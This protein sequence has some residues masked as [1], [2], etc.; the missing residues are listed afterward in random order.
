VTDEAT[1]E[2]DLPY[3]EVLRV[4]HY[5]FAGSAAL[6]G[7]ITAG[8]ALVG[9]GLIVAAFVT[10]EETLALA[11]TGIVL[12]MA[13]GMFTMVAW[14]VAGLAFLTARRLVEHRRWKFCM[15]AAV[16]EGIWLPHGTILG[17]LTITV[18]T[19][20]SV[21]ELFESAEGRLER[22]GAQ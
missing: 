10:G 6:F 21:R 7:C 14:T 11:I 8:D 16:A 15:A 20:E 3:L 2:V 9:I 1:R 19:R 5:L 18:L 17:V 22:R 4:F 13:G 12:A